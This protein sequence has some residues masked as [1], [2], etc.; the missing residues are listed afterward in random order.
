MVSNWHYLL[1]NRV[2]GFNSTGTSIGVNE[3]TAKSYIGHTV[4]TSTFINSSIGATFEVTFNET[5]NLECYET[6]RLWMHYM[7]KRHSGMFAPSFNGYMYE[8]GFYDPGIITDA[9]L[10]LHPYDRAIDYAAT[11]FDIITDETGMKILF[12]C[13]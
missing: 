7:D 12:W 13:K 1:S 2:D 10:I 11:L 8:N 6:L 3:N 9:G 4:T 5:K